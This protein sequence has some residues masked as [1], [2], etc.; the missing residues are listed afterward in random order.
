MKKNNILIAVPYTV[1]SSLKR[2]WL[3]ESGVYFR[4]WFTGLILKAAADGRDAKLRYDDMASFIDV[5]I[6]VFSKFKNNMLLTF[7][8]DAV[9]LITRKAAEYK[10]GTGTYLK[11]LSCSL[12]FNKGA[13]GIGMKEFMEIYNFNHKLSGD[14]KKLFNFILPAELKPSCLQLALDNDILVSDL[15]K[16][17]LASQFLFNLPQDNGRADEFNSCSS[18]NEFGKKILLNTKYA[19]KFFPAGQQKKRVCLVSYLNVCKKFS[20][21]EA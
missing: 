1:Y 19:A 5:S 8:D 6:A 20:Y 10:C 21:Q 15:Y 9:S 14:E 2:R 7:D 17:F 13:N 16:I 4:Q 3:R 18:R 11:I 12:A